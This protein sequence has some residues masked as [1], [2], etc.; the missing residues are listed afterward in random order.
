MRRGLC[1]ASTT[2]LIAWPVLSLLLLTAEGLSLAREDESTASCWQSPCGGS[3]RSHLRIAAVDGATMASQSRTNCQFVSLLETLAQ[4]TQAFRSRLQ[5]LVNSYTD[6]FNNRQLVAELRSSSLQEIV[7]L[8]HDALIEPDTLEHTMVNDERILGQIYT[9]VLRVG[10]LL[11]HVDMP[12]QEVILTDFCS[13]TCRLHAALRTTSPSL[14][15]GAASHPL[16]VLQEVGS[17][18]G[19]SSRKVKETRYKVAVKLDMAAGAMISDFLL[20]A[21]YY[22]EE[23]VAAGG[24]RCPQ[25]PVAF[26]QAPARIVSRESRRTGES[27]RGQHG[28]GFFYLLPK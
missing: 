3:T 18:V 25:A 11:D 27:A 22:R 5:D 26:Q 8:S 23:V 6:D 13:S 14:V 12:L 28:N 2:V 24:A 4:E 21:G 7:S 16:D 19:L 9:N 17:L 20:L 1:W 10:A 15:V